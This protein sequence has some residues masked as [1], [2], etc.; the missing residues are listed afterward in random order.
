MKSMRALPIRNHE[1]QRMHVSQQI[2]NVL[3]AQRLA[4]ARHLVAA[5][6]DDVGH[7]FIVG[8]QPAQRKIFVLEDSL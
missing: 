6:S 8:G 7:A 4:V 1:L 5:E 3:W 2:L